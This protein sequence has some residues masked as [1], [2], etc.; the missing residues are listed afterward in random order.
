MHPVQTNCI[1]ILLLAMP[2]ALWATELEGVVTAR[3]DG[4]LMVSVSPREAAVP[5]LDDPVRFSLDMQGII[6]NAGSGRVVE[7]GNGYV[8]V[9]RLTGNPD[10]EHHAVI[11]ASGTTAP[12]PRQ[13]SAQAG[14][15]S[16][17]AGG[18]AAG[19]GQRVDEEELLLGTIDTAFAS[20]DFSRAFRLADAGLRRFPTNAW[21]RENHET[22][23]IQAQRADSY[24]QALNTAYQ[25]LGQ[26]DF[27]NSINALRQAMGNASVQCDQD[28]QVLSLLEQARAIAQMDREAAIEQARRRSLANTADSAA[29][30]EQIARKRAQREAIGNLLTGNLLGLLAASNGQDANAAAPKPQPATPEN[31]DVFVQTLIQNSESR[32]REILEKWRASQGW[33]PGSGSPATAGKETTSTTTTAGDDDDLVR[34]RVEQT[35]RDNAEVLERWRQTQGWD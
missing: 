16:A 14:G 22:L 34:Q 19:G 29:Y 12:A 11:E 31:G 5:A 2:S 30:R 15:K 20:C 13:Q 35:E 8:W 24:R 23:R 7:V 10:L 3:R 32:T 33:E 25:A 4:A 18:W 1:L 27:D 17:T 26:S 9:D 28:K 6:V 21:L